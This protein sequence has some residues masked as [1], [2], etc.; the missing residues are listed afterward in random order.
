MIPT[1]YVVLESFP[2]NANGKPTRKALVAPK[3]DEYKTEYEAPRN[4]IEEEICKAYQIALK[5]ERIGIK[6]DFYLIGGDSLK[7]MEFMRACTNDAWRNYCRR[8]HH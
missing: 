6:D 2:L 1:Y 8:D 3:A 4:E 7:S 5:E